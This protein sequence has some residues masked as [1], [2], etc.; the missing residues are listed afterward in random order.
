MTNFSKVLIANRGEIAVRIIRAA[1][2]EGL[3]TVAVYADPDREAVHVALADQAYA[4]GGSSAADSYLVADKILAAAE[5]TGADAV[6]PGYGFLSENAEFARA[7]LNAGLVW[8]GPSPEAIERLGTKSQPA[9]SPRKLAHPG[10]GHQRAGGLRQ[11]SAALRGKAG[12][13]DR[14]QGRPRRWRTGHQG[15]PGA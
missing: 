15:G 10:T 3:S 6:H 14:H 11:G 1:R 9:K 7:V 8:I 2:D 12:P 4:L 5:A 13:A